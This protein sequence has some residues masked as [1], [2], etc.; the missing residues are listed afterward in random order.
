MKKKHVIWTLLIAL[1]ASGL[2]LVACG[3]DD[4]DVELNGTTWVYEMDMGILGKMPMM[5]LRFV[6]ATVV[7]EWE[8]AKDGAPA[9]KMDEG[10][11]TVSGN[12]VTIN[13]DGDT[14]T[15]SV[16]GNNMTFKSTPGMGADGDV[17]FVKK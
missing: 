1:L 4:G 3:D 14:M 16:K 17:V 15:G 8:P 2:L 13:I 7:E 6:S 12:N 5:E 9:E 10:T 11:Y